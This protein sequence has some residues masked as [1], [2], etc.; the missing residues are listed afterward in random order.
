MDSTKWTQ[1]CTNSICLIHKRHLWHSKQRNNPKYPTIIKRPKGS[2]IYTGLCLY[3][4]FLIENVPI[5]RVFENLM[6]AVKQYYQTCHFQKD[7]NWWKMPKFKCDILSKWAIYLY[8]LRQQPPGI[9]EAQATNKSVARMVFILI[10]WLVGFL[11]ENGCWRALEG[12]I[13]TTAVS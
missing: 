11:S 7:K 12:S 3:T 10:C 6:L 2:I 13:Y 9:A 1:K 5:W 4:M 8:L